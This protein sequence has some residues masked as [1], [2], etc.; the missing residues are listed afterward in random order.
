MTK[1]KT[2]ALPQIVA[3]LS[4][5]DII[6]GNISH[7]TASKVLVSASTVVQ[8]EGSAGWEFHSFN[9]VTVLAKPGC[10]GA[11][12]KAQPRVAPFILLIFKKED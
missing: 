12:M 6:K 5:K 11:L 3:K 7:E 9:E 8:S 10:L 2:V 4:L 1:Y